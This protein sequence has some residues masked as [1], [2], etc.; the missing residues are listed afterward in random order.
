VDFGI[1]STQDLGTS[2][3]TCFFQNGGCL[4]ETWGRRQITQK[5][6]VDLRQAAL[7][8]SLN[9]DSMGD[10]LFDK[11]VDDLSHT[12]GLGTWF[13]KNKKAASK[14][15]GGQ[16]INFIIFIEWIFGTRVQK[17]TASPDTEVNHLSHTSSSENVFEQKKRNLFHHQNSCVHL[18]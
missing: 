17:M 11:H 18:K 4:Q 9:N 16:S 12:M 10:P 7:P 13:H 5:W 15:Q 14:P 6:A 1:L 2:L 3:G 8:T